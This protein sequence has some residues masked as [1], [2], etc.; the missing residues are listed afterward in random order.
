MKNLILFSLLAP[1]AWSAPKQPQLPPIFDPPDQLF[2]MAPMPQSSRSVA[3]PLSKHI[4]L[5]YDTERCRI[6]S[7]WQG[8]PLKLFG[9]G[10]HGGK[11]PF[12]CQPNGQSLWGNPPIAPWRFLKARA[13]GRSYMP[14]KTKFIGPGNHSC[15]GRNRI[16]QMPTM[17]IGDR[18]D[19][20]GVVGDITGLDD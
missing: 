6:H 17:I 13:L 20:C 18:L 14:C 19:D 8:G 3:V 7:V 2:R 12:I 11:R 9:P 5:A 4:F 10:Y 16:G 1:F 15:S